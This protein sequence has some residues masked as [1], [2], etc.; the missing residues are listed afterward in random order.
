LYLSLWIK[1]FFFSTSLSSIFIHWLSAVV[2]LS[3]LHF[4]FKA[5]S[6]IETP[7]G[8]ITPENVTPPVSVYLEG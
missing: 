4:S 7:S 8:Q 2:V 1:F 6:F 3:L 5:A